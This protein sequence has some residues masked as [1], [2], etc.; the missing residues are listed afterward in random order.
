MYQAHIHPET[1]A[2]QTIREHSEHTA[3]LSRDF[4]IPPLRQVL[5]AA[6][7]LHD[8]GKYQLSFQ[9]K[10]A[11][12]NIR[13]EHSGCGAQAVRAHY[14]GVSALM[15][16]SCILGHHSGLPDSGVPSDLP[17][18]STL[19]G[20]LKREFEDYSAYLKELEIPP[21]DDVAFQRFLMQDC[22]SAEELIDKY[23]FFTRYCFSCLTDADSLD[24]AAF[25]GR[26]QRPLRAD[27]AACLQKVSSRL[28]SFVCRTE[29]QRARG[30]LQRQ[31]FDRVG[32]DAELY[33]MNMPTGSGKTLCSLRFALERAVRTG[34]KRILYIIPYNSIIDQ[35]ADTFEALLGQDAELLRHQSTFTPDSRADYEEDYRQALKAAAENWDAGLIVTTAVQFFESVYAN[36]RGKLRKLHN[37]ADS[38]LIFD[39]A[40]LMP[41]AYLQP[42]L[43]AVYYITR[44]L[45]SEAVFLTATMPDFR[46]LL[47]RY[48]P[49]GCRI[50]DLVPDTSLFPKFQKCRYRYLGEISEE[51][52]ISRATASPSAL[53]VVNRRASARSL[54]RLCPGKTYH[55]STYMTA[56]D[57]K[58]VIAEVREALA[59]LEQDFPDGTQVP[60]S[61]RITVVSTSLI[62]AGVDLDFY[63]VF[64]ELAGLDNI[65]QA[66][67]RCNRE[68][69]R[70]DAEVTVFRLENGRQYGVE[71]ARANLTRE[72]LDAR[73]EVS[74]PA[75]IQEYYH[76]L[77]SLH[78]EELSRNSMHCRCRDL[79]SIP[80]QEYSRDFELID[81]NTV[82]VIVERDENSAA[83]LREL[84][85]GHP[86][87]RKLQQYACTVYRWEF[88]SLLN[89]HVVD[90]Y[91]SGIWCLTNL[92]YYDPDTGLLLEGPDYYL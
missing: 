78:P 48:V 16:E 12:E 17:E 14:R 61:R 57:R 60:D 28:S 23:A 10:L 90:D 39:E 36:K 1:G 49:A 50:L 22:S 5:Y 4:A 76:R 55:L 37:M 70:P 47:R 58:R 75:V 21:V 92:N 82:S 7:L 56:Y 52:L 38:I 46:D 24:T 30:A 77:F 89:Q 51:S 71:E 80:F 62:E 8:V 44:Y 81:S 34:K 79:R 72:L 11:G 85:A 40:H 88:D 59:A 3:A 73:R 31:A 9:R 45:N 91:G 86:N 2:P 63:A 54:Y 43:Q 69:K 29:L 84:R 74:D 66:G 6:G 27:F 64:R 67:G 87:P 83:L 65:L 26:R 13:V 15:M 68:G 19:Y 20:R 18:F 42:C 35:T 33:L 32:Q 41:Q 53:I 25:C